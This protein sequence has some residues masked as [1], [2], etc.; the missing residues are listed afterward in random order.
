MEVRWFDALELNVMEVR[1][2][3]HINFNVIKVM[4]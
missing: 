1:G 2:L 3:M 4:Y